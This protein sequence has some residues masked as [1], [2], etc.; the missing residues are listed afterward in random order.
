MDTW[1]P[2]EFQDMK[3]GGW[4]RVAASWSC[5]STK[6]V[7]KHETHE[8]TFRPKGGSCK[9]HVSEDQIQ[10]LHWPWSHHDL[11]LSRPRFLTI[12]P[13]Q[14]LVLAPDISTAENAGHM[15]R[16]VS[17]DNCKKKN[18]K[19]NWNPLSRHSLDITLDR[20]ETH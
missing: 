3:G 1:S 9:G 8:Q 17:N 14:C 12:P 5:A 2:W 4:G 7:A 15:R 11:L 19:V 20:W 16:P 6:V 13:P 10:N 18:D